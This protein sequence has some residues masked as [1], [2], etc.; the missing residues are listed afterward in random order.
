LPVLNELIERG[1]DRRSAAAGIRSRDVRLA[2]V[3]VS[4]HTGALPPQLFRALPDRREIIGGVRSGH[5]SLPCV[6]VERV[7][8]RDRLENY[9]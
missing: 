3:V 6:F 1:L 2:E 9:G 7:F 8:A 5:L 4:R